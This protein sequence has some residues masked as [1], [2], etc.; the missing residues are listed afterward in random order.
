MENVLFK[1]SFPRN[2]TP[3]PRRMRR[4]AAMRWSR[5]D[6]TRSTVSSDDAGVAI[7]IY[8]QDGSAAQPGDRDHSLQY[9]VAIP[10]LF[11]L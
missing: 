9:I 10:L 3:R 5:I 8:Q 2:F 11:A 1:I 7:R 4:Q 6:S